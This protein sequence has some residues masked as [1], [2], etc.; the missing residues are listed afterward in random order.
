MARDDQFQM[1]FRFE[2][3]RYYVRGKTEREVI[4]K[5]ALK[6]EELKKAPRVVK[7]NMKV[8][9]WFYEYMKIYKSDISEK[10]RA[11]YIGIYENAIRAYIGPYM[12]KDVT[13]I[14]CQKLLN[15][16]SGKSKSYIHKAEMIMNW[17]FNSA[18]DNDFILV[19]PMR[20]C[21]AP[22]GTERHR[23][24]MTKEEREI[25][26]KASDKLSNAGLFC[27]VIYYCGLRPSEVARIQGKDINRKEN[28]LHVQG[29]KTKAAERIVPIPDVFF[30]RLPKINKDEL[31]FQTSS[32]SQLDKR[33]IEHY[34]ASVKRQMEIEAGNPPD[35]HGYVE[36]KLIADDLTMY[37]LRH[38][39]CT[40][41]QEKGVEIDIARR[42]M[43]HSDIR[44]TSQ[45]YTHYSED[46]LKKA[47]EL[48]NK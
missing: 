15:S 23:R 47:A 41:L 31:L 32:G 37:C 9:D 29:K 48:I 28:T 43:G 11:D 40:R 18:I 13:P 21:I 42:L 34:W 20:G 27:Q 14:N 22:K 10:C 39:Y 33:R 30:K 19:S 45:I 17:I 7:G 6:R 5:L 2:G 46:T 44:V 3:K 38:D 26:I 8:N 16:M 25:F 24:A 12:L 1:S 35:K 36:P 4:E